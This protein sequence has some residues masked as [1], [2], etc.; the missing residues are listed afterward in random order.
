[1]MSSSKG[2]RRV[3]PISEFFLTRGEGGVVPFLIFS[4]KRGREGKAKFKKTRKQHQ[5]ARERFRVAGEHFGQYFTL[6]SPN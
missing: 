6:F 3:S 4:A 2:G 5:R 1:M